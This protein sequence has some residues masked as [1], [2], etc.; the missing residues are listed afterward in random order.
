[1]PLNPD[2]S[3]PPYLQI[4]EDLTTKIESGDLG[5]GAKLPSRAEMTADYG[6]AG[7]TVQH[8]LSVLKERGLIV[9]RQGQGTFVKTDQG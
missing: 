9:A 1:M 4:V 2:D 3:R 7:M 5:P 8:A 6:V